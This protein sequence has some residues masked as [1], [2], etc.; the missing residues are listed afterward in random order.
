MTKLTLILIALLLAGCGG[1]AGAFENPDGLDLQRKPFPYKSQFD[2]YMAKNGMFKCAVYGEK[3]EDK[4]FTNIIQMY[5]TEPEEG[6][7][8]RRKLELLSLAASDYLDSLSGS[9]REYE[10]KKLERLKMAVKEAR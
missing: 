6:R 7:I 1:N 9:S 8:R 5:C 2:D 4:V 10:A 3:D